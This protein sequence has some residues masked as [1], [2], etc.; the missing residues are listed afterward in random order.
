M[1]VIEHFERG[2][3][4]FRNRAAVIEGNGSLTYAEMEDRMI[5]IAQGLLR[6]DLPLDSSVALLSPN[7]SMVLACQ[8]GIFKAGMLWVPINYRNSVSDNLAQLAKYDTRLLFFHS[9]LREHAVA[10]LA[11]LPELKHAICIDAKI[12]GFPSLS[13]W[14]SEPRDVTLAFPIREMEDAVAISSTGGTTGEPKGAIHTN[15]SFEAVVASVYAL[16]QFDEPPVHLIVAPLTHA[17]AIFHYALLP[18][19][20]T[21][22]LLS[23]TDPLAV[24]EAI[25]QHRVSV[26]YLPPT[27]IYMVLAH[28]RL[29]DFDLSSLR[30]LLYGAAPMSVDKLREA[31]D[32]FGPILIQSY[33]QTECL[34]FTTVLT[35]KD[36][37]EILANPDLQHRLAS[38][39]RSGPFSRTE[40]VTEA[41]EIAADDEMGEIAFRSAMQMTEFYKD[42]DATA[43]IRRNGWQFSGDLG[44]RDAD[45]YIYIVDRKRDMIISG[46]FNVFPGEVE[47]VVLG[48]PAVLDCVVVGIPHEKWGEMVTAAIEVKDGMSIDTA[49]LLAL[50][51]E[52]LGSIKAPK[53]IDIWPEL[54][55]ST[56]GKTLRRAVRDH[57][58]AGMDRKI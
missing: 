22:I 18:R 41:G 48:H 13:D 53:Q 40:V 51:K 54:P 2:V 55:R 52:R 20:G 42:P 4:R 16:F 45:G 37:E 6:S 57:Y 26:V 38:V 47:Q 14:F 21:Q 44:R 5:R 58:W 35:P 31:C 23:S 49:E 11:A 39:G 30:Y 34:Q 43:A 36:H 12:D 28:P 56:A 7:H 32:V 15:R 29:K 9:S 24:L 1:L 50:C 8:Y 33:G 19:G 10:A 3:E 25:Q 46:G 17:A 27:L